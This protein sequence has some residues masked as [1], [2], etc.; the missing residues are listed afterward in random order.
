MGIVIG[1]MVEDETVIPFKIYDYCD[2][3][4]LEDQ[5]LMIPWRIVT[6]RD[7]TDQVAKVRDYLNKNIR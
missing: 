1:G 7:K 5:D 3:G 6:E 2:R 4:V